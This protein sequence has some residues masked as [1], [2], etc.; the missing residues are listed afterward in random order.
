MNSN[1][2]YSKEIV[3][4]NGIKKLQGGNDSFTILTF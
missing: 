4:L 3:S 2:I 1:N